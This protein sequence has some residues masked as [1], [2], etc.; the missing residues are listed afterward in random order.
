MP[1]PD[2]WRYLIY[3]LTVAAGLG[4]AV[5]TLFLRRDILYTLRELIPTST[6]ISPP[7]QRRTRLVWLLYWTCGAVA[8]TAM[9]IAGLA[10]S[11]NPQSSSPPS[12]ISTA[13]QTET[14]T[15][16]NSPTPPPAT[17]VP[18]QEIKDLFPF[19]LRSTWTFNFSMLSID[20]SMPTSG[21]FSTQVLMI[22]SGQYDKVRIIQVEQKG[23]G[24]VNDC[25]RSS[26]ESGGST[27]WYVADQ[28]RLYHACSSSEAT[29]IALDL[30]ASEEPETLPA[31]DLVTPLHVGQ[32]W[33]AFPDTLPTVAPDYH[34]YVQSQGRVSVPAGEFMDCYRITL[35]TL[36]DTTIRWVCPG[37][38]LV[39]TEYHHRTNGTSY[40]AELIDLKIEISP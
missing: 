9:I 27:T 38:G 21:T 15:T 31:P 22:E 32:Y 3:L 14:P 6:K 13:L 8:G 20:P 5:L 2:G 12:H 1:I 19:Y 33:A 4:F 36:P 28:Y 10:T 24:Y 16:M 29:S 39:A 23:H 34:W 11:P 7:P 35:H 26:W 40:R 25:S 18:Q 30:N 17:D 37:M